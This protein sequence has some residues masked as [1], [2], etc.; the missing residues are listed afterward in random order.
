MDD[1]TFENKLI[2]KLKSEVDGNK[3]TLE[4][5]LGL[6]V[7]KGKG[8]LI[9]EAVSSWCLTLLVRGEGAYLQ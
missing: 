5:T 1:A 4:K 3:N 6:D 8:K 7:Q 2:S 9:L